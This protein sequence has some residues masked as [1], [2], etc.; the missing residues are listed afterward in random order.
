M[1]NSFI[2][3]Y[4]PGVFADRAVTPPRDM[5]VDN[6]C[7]NGAT[8]YTRVNGYICACAEG[9]IGTFCGMFYTVTVR[10]PS[11]TATDFDTVEHF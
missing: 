1:F 9:F 2:N 10:E 3:D 4:L 8:C 7:E 6:Q 5:C 11:D